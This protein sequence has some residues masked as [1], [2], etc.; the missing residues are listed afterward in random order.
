MRIAA[1][2]GQPHPDRVRCSYSDLAGDGLVRV[3]GIVLAEVREA[4]LGTPL[5][6]MRVSVH[7]FG[8]R[9]DP[10]R[11]RAALAEGAS[12]PHGDFLIE[13]ELRRGDYLL[14]ARAQDSEEVLA[15]SRFTLEDDPP[16]D[17]A[18]LRLVVPR[19]PVIASPRAEEDRP[20][21]L[22]DAPPRP[23]WAETHDAAAAPGKPPEG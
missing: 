2:P 12:D 6:G 14:V 22:P 20:S 3:S 4:P 5:A 11:P 16:S 13:A 15:Y 9:D 1:E 19:G 7:P 18:D 8:E 23:A 21:P 10:R 17:R